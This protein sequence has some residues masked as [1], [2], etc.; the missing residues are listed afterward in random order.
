MG[1]SL[2]GIAFRVGHEGTGVENLVESLCQT[3]VKE[4]PWPRS[5]EFDIRNTNDVMVQRFEDVVFVFNGSIVDKLLFD[6]D[7]SVAQ[8]IYHAI[9]EPSEFIAFCNYDSGGSYGFAIVEN[10]D[11]SRM[12]VQVSGDF[13]PCFDYGS[14]SEE[15]MLWHG[16]KVKFYDSEGNLYKKASLLDRVANFLLSKN[17]KVEERLFKV[18]CKGED[19]LHDY[20][21]TERVLNDILIKRYQCCPWN[22]EEDL[23][24]YFFKGSKTLSEISGISADFR[25]EY[26]FSACRETSININYQHYECELKFDNLDRNVNVY[27]EFL[28]DKGKPVKGG[29]KVAEI[30]AATIW[31]RFDFYR[32]QL[33]FLDVGSKAKVYYRHRDE[34]LGEVCVDEILDLRKNIGLDKLLQLS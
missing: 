32:E 33:E 5:N 23:S 9:G 1:V 13:P 30:G 20:E 18:Y 28:D 34:Y 2:A 3:D 19:E 21:L 17:N 31:L 26:D 8:H 16:A 6:N 11:V 7:Q 12:R 15:E 4:I 27:M 10:G 25:V 22:T 29:D 24:Q 14:L